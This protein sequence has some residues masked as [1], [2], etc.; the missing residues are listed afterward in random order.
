MVL[1][2][3]LSLQSQCSPYVLLSNVG[4]IFHININININACYYRYL[5]WLRN[6]LIRLR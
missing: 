3:D 6:I 4:T 5:M 2:S 1:S